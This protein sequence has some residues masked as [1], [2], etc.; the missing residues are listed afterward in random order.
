MRAWPIATITVV[1]A[2]LVGC[3]TTTTAIS[4]AATS[5][6]RHRP[7]RDVVPA[8][9]AGAA[10][11]MRGDEVL[12]SEGFG[13]ANRSSDL[14]NT[15][16]TVFQLASVSKQ[17][18]AAGILR[19]QADGRLHVDDPIGHHLDSVPV[20]KQAI[21]IHQLL[22]HTSGLPHRVGECSSHVAALDREAYLQQVLSVPLEAAPG[23]RHVYSNDGYGVL[24]AIIERVSGQPYEQFL[25]E[26]LFEPAGMGRTGYTFAPDI[27]AAA[28]RGYGER[29]FLGNLNP[30]FRNAS[31]PAWCNRASGGLL[32]TT[33]DMQRWMQALRAGRVLPADE[34]HAML[35]PHVFE[36]PDNAS[37]FGYGWA[38]FR[39]SRGTRLAA[40]DGSLSGFYTAELRWYL[41]EDVVVYVV[42]N[43]S[44]SPA[45]PVARALSAALLL[46]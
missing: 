37:H 41:D 18:T 40:H 44:E 39:T 28:A 35:S 27:V 13:L 1:V 14:P 25:R 24:G 36:A 12:L 10:L 22:I 33:R 16:E 34:M 3:G 2:V 15:A 38:I 45:P 6:A 11:V 9:F 26:R 30:R 4:S 21:T 29:E 17:F 42:A 20:D 32:S 8:G 31:G 19:L 7:L 46:R 5:E 23:T 43:T